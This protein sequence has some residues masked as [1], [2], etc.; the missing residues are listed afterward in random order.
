[1]YLGFA[2]SPLICWVLINTKLHCLS[3]KRTTKDKLHYFCTVNQKA[4]L[5]TNLRPTIQATYNHAQSSVT[6]LFTFHLGTSINTIM[7]EELRQF[8]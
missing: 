3:D 7:K 1:M 5:T 2:R 8:S 4:A 6:A